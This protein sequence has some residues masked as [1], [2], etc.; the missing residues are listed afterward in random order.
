[1]ASLGE[2]FI[3]LAFEGDTSKAEEFKKKIQ[4]VTKEQKKSEISFKSAK[5]A[6]LG[7]VAALTG[8]VYAVKRLTD[9]LVSQ[10]Q[11]WINLT[12]TSDMALST[13][14]K[15]DSIGQMF[16]INNAAEQI[17]N[18][19]DRI[20]ELKLTGANAQGFMLAGINPTNADDVMQQLR[21][22]VSGLS[23]TSASYLLQQLGIDPNMLHLLRMTEKEF[24]SLTAEMKKFQL[25]AEQ[26]KS[27]QEMNIQM[28]IAS[29]KLKYLKDRAILAILP[30]WTELLKLFAN[31]AASIGRFVGWLSKLNPEFTKSIKI[32][33][34]VTAGLLAI[35]SA[36]KI[37]RGAAIALKAVLTALK[38]DPIY[39]GIT[40]IIGAL[41]LLADDIRAYM[42]GG[43]SIIGVII[44]ALEDIQERL[45]FETPQ[46][47]KDLLTIIHNWQKVR[48]LAPGSPE[49]FENKKE[50]G[51]AT[52]NIGADIA[53]A[54][55]MQIPFIGPLLKTIGAGLSVGGYLNEKSAERQLKQI[56]NTSNRTSNSNI[57]QNN[58]IYTNETAGV[59]Q[60]NLAQVQRT[61]AYQIA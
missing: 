25:T 11:Q 24:N 22:R 42:S 47:I 28:Q 59:V 35:A 14:Q 39:L 50:T 8:A 34:G 49:Y 60:N 31:T 57:T 7:Y 5:T 16:G 17:K 45:N 43:G 12:R 48:D 55:I 21:R 52:K 1:M 3:E 19:N 6:L 27:I 53:N 9:S 44:K 20:F 26:R 33:A 46:W 56:N 13:F 36:I 40:L 51:A 18:L 10:N 23:D 30:V 2:L 29:Q 37:I 38:F 54:P 32:I 41:A 4:E 61:V 58:T 15:W